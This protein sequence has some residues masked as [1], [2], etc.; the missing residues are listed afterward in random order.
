M[1]C[2]A[3]PA[4]WAMHGFPKQPNDLNTHRCIRFRLPTL[5][6]LLNWEFIDPIRHEKQ[7]WVA[8]GGLIVNN[9]QTAIQ[10]ALDRLG[11]VWIERSAVAGYLERG[12]LTTALDE[13]AMHFRLTISTTRTAPLLPC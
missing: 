3:S 4:Y 13:W 10:G 5:G 2:V 6:G 11:V 12:E 9:T 8:Q 7:V 1:C